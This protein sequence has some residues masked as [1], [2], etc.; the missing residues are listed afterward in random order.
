M[1][2]IFTELRC[3]AEIFVP[4][5]ITAVSPHVPFTV[6]WVCAGA[7][8]RQEVKKDLL[9]SR[10]EP[11]DVQRAAELEMSTAGPLKA[12]CLNDTRLLYLSFSF[13]VVITFLLI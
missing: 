5:S 8:K 1:S 9:Q 2:P 13:A 12:P 11:G 6:C 4:A 7:L 3:P 10:A